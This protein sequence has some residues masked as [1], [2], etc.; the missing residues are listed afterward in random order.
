MGALGYVRGAGDW[1]HH[2]HRRGLAQGADP[3]AVPEWS[4]GAA[5]PGLRLLRRPTKGTYRERERERIENF[6]VSLLQPMTK[7]CKTEG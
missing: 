7:I 2:F 3:I 6:E 5:R 4:A 1:G